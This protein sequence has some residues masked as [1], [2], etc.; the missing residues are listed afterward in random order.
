[1][2]RR[3]HGGRG[4][5]AVGVVEVFLFSVP[6]FLFF[7][8]SFSW[9]VVVVVAAITNQP[10]GLGVLFFLTSRESDKRSDESEM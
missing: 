3:W 4:G 1:M 10:L 7:R 9:V 8:P 2:R 6:F 5:Y